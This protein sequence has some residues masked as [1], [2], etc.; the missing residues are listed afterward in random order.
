MILI[1]LLMLVA[2]SA[3]FSVLA[4][5]AAERYSAVKPPALAPGQL[6]PIS[7]LK[8]LHGLDLGIIENLRSFFVQ[9]YPQ[10]EILFAVET[11][12]DAAVPIVRELIRDIPGIPARL[13]IAGP[14]PYP[15]AKV[16]SLRCMM[17]EATHEVIVMADS[18]VRV[19]PDFLRVI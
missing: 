13:L 12:D 5:V 19:T 6:P 3:V 15:N 2:G 10:F 16:H 11:E 1:L 9:D 17:A 14:S 8:P 18:D 7:I 4:I